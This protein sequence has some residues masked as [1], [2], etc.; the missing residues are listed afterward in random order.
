[1]WVTWPVFVNGHRWGTRPV[2][3]VGV[4]VA[5]LTRPD[6][7]RRCVAD[8]DVVCGMW[9]TWR[10]C[11]GVA[12]GRRGVVEGGGENDVVGFRHMCDWGYY[13]LHICKLAITF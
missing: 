1:M 11:R 12:C 2:D 7:N 4:D 9:S 5:V 8:V 3:V 13:K 6:R 10:G